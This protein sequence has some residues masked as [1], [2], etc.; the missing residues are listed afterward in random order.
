MEEY[1]KQRRGEQG[2]KR[3]TNSAEMGQK[4]VYFTKAVVVVILFFWGK[5]D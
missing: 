1:S 4:I 5:K 2:G 3:G